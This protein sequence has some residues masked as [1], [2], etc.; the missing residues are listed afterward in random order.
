[1]FQ[2]RTTPTEQTQAAPSIHRKITLSIDTDS[3]VLTG[4]N[5]I[6]EI[7]LDTGNLSVKDDYMPT[8]T[9]RHYEIYGII[10]FIKLLSSQPLGQIQGKTIYAITRIAVVPFE[11]EEACRV[12]DRRVVREVDE[13]LSSTSDT[14]SI[15]IPSHGRV[16]SEDVDPA[17][18]MISERE[19]SSTPESTTPLSQSLSTEIT[20]TKVMSTDVTSSRPSRIEAFRQPV[21]SLFAKMKSAFTKRPSSAA[22]DTSDDADKDGE[23]ESVTISE[24]VVFRQVTPEGEYKE[25]ENDKKECK[26]DENDKKG[27]GAAAKRLTVMA[28]DGLKNEVVGVRDVVGLN[29]VSDFK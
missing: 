15:P 7:D 18:I 12:L 20:E 11:Y 28:W 25:D 23:F 29:N 4:G 21:N 3:F 26:E 14:F 22:S 9:T 2:R 17:T 1:M 8:P 24:T 5:D 6:V 19:L 16:T 10:G 13:D 27:F